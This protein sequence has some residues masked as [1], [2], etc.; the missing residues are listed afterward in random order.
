MLIG[1]TDDNK[2]YAY[3][4]C[5]FRQNPQKPVMIIEHTSQV[6]FDA[7]H[8]LVKGLDLKLTTKSKKVSFVALCSYINLNEATYHFFMIFFG[9][10]E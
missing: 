2:D 4:Y 6:I 10:R 7:N 9:F 5:L 3:Y 1:L 8:T